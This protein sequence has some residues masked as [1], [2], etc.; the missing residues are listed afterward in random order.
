MHNRPGHCVGGRR[1]GGAVCA[2][3]TGV[4]V[5]LAV[6]MVCGCVA[7]YVVLCMGGLCMVCVIG[8]CVAVYV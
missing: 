4:R 2:C 8:T 1:A 7:M 3:E 6:C 5:Q